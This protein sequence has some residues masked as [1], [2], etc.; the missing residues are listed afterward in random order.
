MKTYRDAMTEHKLRE[1]RR[2]LRSAGGCVSEASRLGHVNRQW[3][4]KMIK[5][6]KLQPPIRRVKEGNAAWRDLGR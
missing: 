3:L 2:I 5:R 6:H 4:H 1:L